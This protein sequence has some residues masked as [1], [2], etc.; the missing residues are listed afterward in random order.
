MNR[1]IDLSEEAY[2][3]NPIRNEGMCP[4]PGQSGEQ[5]KIMYL[6]KQISKDHLLMMRS[7]F[8]ERREEGAGQGRKK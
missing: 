6:K 4:C 7:K 3:Y 2:E 1:L 5:V 8:S